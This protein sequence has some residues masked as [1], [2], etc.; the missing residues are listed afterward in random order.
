MDV[1]GLEAVEAGRMAC[2]EGPC[3]GCKC[4]TM[5]RTGRRSDE[6]EA[7]GSSL[8]LVHRSWLDHNDQQEVNRGG[9]QYV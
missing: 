8:T 1:L 4:H 7:N 5:K 9:L 6:D 2:A 3:C